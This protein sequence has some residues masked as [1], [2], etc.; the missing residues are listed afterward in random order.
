MD[1][2]D[3]TAGAPA[4]AAAGS[5]AGAELVT[6]GLA[7]GP[8]EVAPRPASASTNAAATA[9]SASPTS[10]GARFDPPDAARSAGRSVEIDVEL[11]VEVGVDAD[12]VVDA[13]VGVEPAADAGVRRD[14]AGSGSVDAV[15]EGSAPGDWPMASARARRMARAFGNR[16][17]IAN[18]SARSTA[19]ATSGGALGHTLASGGAGLVAAA[20]SAS[21]TLEVTWGGRPARRP[22]SIAPTL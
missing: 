18:A 20:T 11:C 2:L 10:Q 3:S 21:L 13:D 1:A 8:A 19:V 17:S 9:T 12:A 15:G 4:D 7:S 14:D 5:A 6:T 22:K 16:S